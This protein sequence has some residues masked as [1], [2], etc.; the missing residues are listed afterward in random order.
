MRRDKLVLK[1]QYV[2]VMIEFSIYPIVS[3]A[4]SSEEYETTQYITPETL[5]AA[6]LATVVGL[7]QSFADRLKGLGKKIKSRCV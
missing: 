7:G 1:I 6:K 3:S 5:Q 4:D 2:I